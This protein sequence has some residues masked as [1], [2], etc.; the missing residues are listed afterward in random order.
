MASRCNAPPF[1][2]TKSK[3]CSRCQRERPLSA[4][5]RHRHRKDGLDSK[6][7]QCNAAAGK[8]WYRRR[9]RDTNRLY[10]TYMGMICRCHC[11]SHS[12]FSAYGGRGISV[13][14]EWRASFEAFVEWANCNGYQPSLQLDRIDNDGGYSPDNCRFVTAADNAQN[15]RPRDT[16][17]RTN[18]TLTVEQVRQV[19]ALLALGVAQRQ[20]ARQFGVTHTTIWAIKIGRTWKDVN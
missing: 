8:E 15:K 4:F 13:C 18:P 9:Q 11:E 14:D 5:N 16:P 12:N 1:V 2:G 19:K 3:V 20:I 17:M 10:S 7:K 6:C